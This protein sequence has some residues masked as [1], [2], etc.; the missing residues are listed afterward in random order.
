MLCISAVKSLRVGHTAVW[1]F[2]LSW[3][4]NQ[5]QN[6]I[7][8]QFQRRS[9]FLDRTVSDGNWPQPSYRA[10]E[11]DEFATFSSQRD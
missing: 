4:C 5:A 3:F 7:V 10:S 1:L 2:L 9:R 6:Q 11:D 8:K